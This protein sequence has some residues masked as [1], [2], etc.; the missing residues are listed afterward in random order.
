MFQQI[1]A[2]RGESG[3]TLVELIVVIA[4]LGVLAGVAVFSLSSV[5]DNG[6]LSACKT[7]RATIVTG[8]AVYLTL[9][10]SAAQTFADLQGTFSP[11]AA[12]TPVYGPILASTP[13]YFTM[14]AG[15]ISPT[16]TAP[17][18]C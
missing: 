5:G 7:E 11:G 16:T 10:G 6:A 18:G 8:Q 9:K 3:F 4:I 15:A 14:A 17:S 12:T 2:E 1:R 13:K